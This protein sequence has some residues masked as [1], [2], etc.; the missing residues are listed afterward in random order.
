[1]KAPARLAAFALA[2]VVALGGGYAVGVAAGPIDDPA[3]AE[4]NTHDGT[5]PVTPPSTVL[6]DD[7]HG[8]DGMRGGEP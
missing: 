8:A 3:P 6:H 1:M 5:E 2:G 4:H 7:G